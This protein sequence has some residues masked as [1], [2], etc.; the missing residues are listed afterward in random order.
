MAPIGLGAGG[1]FLE[2]VPSSILVFFFPQLV[3][4]EVVF[5]D[6]RVATVVA[7]ALGH[8]SGSDELLYFASI[9]LNQFIIV[10]RV[11]LYCGDRAMAD[12]DIPSA[13]FF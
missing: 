13:L 8:A 11:T 10:C 7:R 2:L 3:L 1:L 4:P 6:N 5:G 9:F 12:A